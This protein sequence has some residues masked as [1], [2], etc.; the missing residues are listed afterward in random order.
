MATVIKYGIKMWEYTC[1][2]CKSTI[3]FN[4]SAVNKCSERDLGDP[5]YYTRYYVSCPNC[6]RK[7]EVSQHIPTI[8]KT[9]SLHNR[10]AYD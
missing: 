6:H 1:Q 10:T 9:T 8:Y 3:K 5:E 7:S 2:E 4:E